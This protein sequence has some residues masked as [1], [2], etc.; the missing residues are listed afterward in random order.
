MNSDDSFLGKGKF[1]KVIKIENHM[2]EDIALKKIDSSD[3]NLIEIDILSRVKSPYLLRSIGEI[4]DNVSE[5][6]EG[7]KLELKEDNLKNLNRKDLTPGQTIRIIMSLIYGLE[8]LHKSGFLHLDV[9]PLNCL[10]DYKNGLYTAYLSDFGFSLRCEDPYTGIVRNQRAGSLKYYPYEFLQSSKEY[11]FNDK[12]DVWSLGVTILTFLGMDYIMSFKTENTTEEK[13]QIVKNFWDKNSPQ[14]LIHQQVNRE[15]YDREGYDR[16]GYDREGYDEEGYNEEGYNREGYDRNGRDRDGYN[17]RG[18]RR[19]YDRNGFNF[20]GYNAE[21]IH[22]NGYDAEGYDRFGYDRDGHHRVG[23]N[24]HG[25]DVHGFDRRGL[26]RAGRTFL[27][28]YILDQGFE[29]IPA[30]R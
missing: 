23:Y 16:E 17:T 1:G 4:N 12:S 6:F 21:G 7:I 13:T 18:Y 3:L 20:A 8:C 14:K 29:I 10:Y 24:R 26:N 11:F 30:S 2:G 9:K 28:Q 27:E 25:Y 19:G 15:G 5:E 22:R